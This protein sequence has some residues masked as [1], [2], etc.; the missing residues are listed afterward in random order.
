[1]YI[2]ICKILIDVLSLSRLADQRLL[3]CLFFLVWRYFWPDT[4]FFFFIH[5]LIRRDLETISVRSFDR[6]SRHKLNLGYSYF[7]L[8]Q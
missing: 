4:R 3:S 5:S 2:N 1:M 7:L 8:G 6:G